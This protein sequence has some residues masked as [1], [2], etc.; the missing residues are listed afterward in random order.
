MYSFAMI[1]ARYIARALH[2]VSDMGKEYLCDWMS[3]Y[4]LC[5]S[6]GMVLAVYRAPVAGSMTKCCERTPRRH[7]GREDEWVRRR[8]GEKLQE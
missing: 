6:H 1:Q 4:I 5:S 7:S 3:T 2:T 8:R